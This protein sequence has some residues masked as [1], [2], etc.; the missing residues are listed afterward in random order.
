MINCNG[1]DKWE[2]A[3]DSIV[4]ETAWEAELFAEVIREE[5]L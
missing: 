3:S 2:L 5:F 4:F 1:F